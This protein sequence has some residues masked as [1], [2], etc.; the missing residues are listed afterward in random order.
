M[1]GINS[2]MSNSRE[3]SEYE[4]Q[5]RVP[6]ARQMN[7][8]PVQQLWKIGTFHEKRLNDLETQ[9]HKLSFISKQTPDKTP[10]KNIE[11]LEQSI[12]TLTRK[13]NRL[14]SENAEF[15]KFIQQ[16]KSVSLEIAES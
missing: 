7:G 12:L 14:E 13:I 4:K 10:D 15:R 1:I 8:T 3:H 2:I 11:N 9:V 16:K 5:Q 6:A